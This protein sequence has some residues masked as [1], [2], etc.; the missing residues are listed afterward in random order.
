MAIGDEHF[1]SVPLRINKTKRK[2]NWWYLNLNN[3]IQAS[4]NFSYRNSLKQKYSELPEVREQVSKLPQIRNKV[5][6]Q[7]TIY[8]KDARKFDIPNVYTVVDKFIVDVLV[9]RGILL[10][11]DYRYYPVGMWRWGGID[12]DNP[13]A[14]IVIREIDYTPVNER[15]DHER[16]D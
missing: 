14:D 8:G 1:F 2:E 4:K 11:D 13:R 6:L 16:R 12:R 10:E 7:Y 3:L 9:K 5:Y 15:G